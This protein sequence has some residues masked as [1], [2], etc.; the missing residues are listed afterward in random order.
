[1]DHMGADIAL[2]TGYIVFSRV[3]ERFLIRA[4]FA[5]TLSQGSRHLA[6]E[7]NFES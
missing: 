5:L 6:Q 4:S 2:A 1:M 7:A 3:T